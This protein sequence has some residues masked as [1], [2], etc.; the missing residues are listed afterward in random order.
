[1]L[2]V[3][4]IVCRLRRL[5]EWII[6]LIV[7]KKLKELM[8]ME[9]LKKKKDM[10]KINAIKRAD[11]IL[12]SVGERRKVRELLG[13]VKHL[14]NQVEWN[15][16]RIS[17]RGVQLVSEIYEKDNW[18]NVKS[19]EL[20]KLELEIE[21]ENL[22]RMKDGEVYYLEELRNVVGD[23]DL[24]KLSEDLE[25]YYKGASDWFAGFGVL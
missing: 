16:R 23:S 9:T 2:G 4:I 11:S 15:R 1:M 3:M 8:K 14:R 20:L 22:A 18:G 13:Q 5:T 19:K 10:K 17:L 7:L 25:K 12:M 21:K 6:V 24:K